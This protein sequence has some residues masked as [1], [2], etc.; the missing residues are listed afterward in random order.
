MLADDGSAVAGGAVG[1]VSE[2]DFGAAALVMMGLMARIF[3]WRPD[4]FWRATPEEVASLLQSMTGV[5]AEDSS[6]GGVARAELRQ[7]MEA[8]PDE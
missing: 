8:F 6:R 7:M 1:G 3:G 5:S 4:E 2:G